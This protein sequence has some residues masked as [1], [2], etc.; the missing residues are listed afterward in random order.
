M[1]R[2]SNITRERLV[3]L[4]ELPAH[5]DQFSGEVEAD[6][7]GQGDVL[8]QAACALLRPLSS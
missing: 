5:F 3:K 1:K 2:A 8:D 7:A 6:A 4:R